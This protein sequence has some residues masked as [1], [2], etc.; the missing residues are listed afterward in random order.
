MA[1]R[2]IFGMHVGIF[3]VNPSG[4]RALDNAAADT[5]ASLNTHDT[6]PFMGFWTGADIEDRFQLGLLTEPQAEQ[7]QQFRAAQR[8]ALVEFL[9]KRGFLPKA[10]GTPDAVL[11]GWLEFLAQNEEAFLLINLE[12]LWLEPAPTK[13]PRDMARATQL[14]AQSAFIP[15]CDPPV[16]QYLT[17]TANHQRHPPPTGIKLLKVIGLNLSG[18]DR[19]RP[20]RC[21]K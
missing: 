10:N 16:G 18:A 5:V 20:R 1:R 9:E 6:T 13:Y 19:P 3:G 2:N 11:K 4:E 7:E 12:D 21:R 17:T 15:R 14:A 8:Q